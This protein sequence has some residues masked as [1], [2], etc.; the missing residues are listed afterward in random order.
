M[1]NDRLSRSLSGVPATTASWQPAADV[2][3]VQK[4]WLVKLDLAG[5]RQTDIAVRVEGRELVVSGTR[6]DWRM[7]GCRETH[8]M[9]INYSCFERRIVLPENITESEVLTEY[10]DGMLLVR[11]EVNP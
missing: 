5:V 6:R 3:R 7:E 10:R 4:G 2:Y 9:E 1:M 11:I 8:L